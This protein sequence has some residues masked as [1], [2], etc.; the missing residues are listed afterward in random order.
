VLRA[1]DVRQF[2]YKLVPRAGFLNASDKACFDLGRLEMAWKVVF[3]PSSLFPFRRLLR[4]VC[5]RVGGVRALCCRGPGAPHM[6][7]QA[8][9]WCSMCRHV[10]CVLRLHCTC[11]RLVS[12][13]VA[14]H[15]EYQRL[16]LRYLC[17][18]LRYAEDAC[19][20]QWGSQGA[21]TRW[22]TCSNGSCPL[23]RCPPSAQ[24]MLKKS[25]RIAHA[26]HVCGMPTAVCRACM[27]ACR[28]HEPSTCF[29]V[30][31][32]TSE[33]THMS[34][35]ACQRVQG[36]RGAGPGCAYTHKCVRRVRQSSTNKSSS[37]R[38]RRCPGICARG[39]ARSCTR[40]DGG[41][42]TRVVDD[43]MWCSRPRECRTACKWRRPLP[44]S[45]VSS[46]TLRSLVT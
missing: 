14:C 13:Y 30:S 32:H 1:G 42:G 35:R 3:L 31:L 8:A 9:S 11:C 33:Y 19:R 6:Q 25:A 23:P 10:P 36:C 4:A 44:S 2:V 18:C 17:L 24:I 16:C 39:V 7:A 22:S 27:S 5:V 46:T 41:C 20:L 12:L 38:L 28:V 26:T 40:P 34:A 29:M 15:V 21:C 37:P 43:R 45:C